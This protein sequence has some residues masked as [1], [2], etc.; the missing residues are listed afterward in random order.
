[1]FILQIN[2]HVSLLNKKCIYTL[3]IRYNIIVFCIMKKQMIIKI[4]FSF[5]KIYVC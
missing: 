5:S 3:F 1:M 4:K 2:I